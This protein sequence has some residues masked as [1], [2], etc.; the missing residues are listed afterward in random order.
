[1]E[2]TNKQRDQ[3][4]KDAGYDLVTTTSCEWIK[5]PESKQRY[6]FK[7]QEPMEEMSTDN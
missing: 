4:I 5:M 3:A 1:M 2:K 6:Y 7:E